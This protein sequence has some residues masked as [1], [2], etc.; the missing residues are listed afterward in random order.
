MQLCWDSRRTARGPALSTPAHQSVETRDFHD[1]MAMLYFQE[2]VD[3]VQGPW[4]SAA[5][6]TELWEVTLPQLARTN[7]TL[8]C[9]AIGIGALSTCHHQSTSRPPHSIREEDTHYLTAVKYYCQSLKLLGQRTS[10]QEAV[11]ISVL[12][13]F[14][15]L[16]RGNRKAA[17][18][19][20]NHG[21][22]L[23]LTL[24]TDENAP[25]LLHAL[26]PDP[27]PLLLSVVGI[28]ICLAPQARFLLHGTAGQDRP[29]PHFTRG[30]KNNDLSMESFMILLGQL[31]RRSATSDE[32]PSTFRN[33]EEFEEHWTSLRRRNLAVGSMGTKIVQSSG[34]LGSKEEDVID[35]FYHHLLEDPEINRFC[36]TSRQAMQAVDAAFLPLFNRI[37]MSGSDSPTFLKAVHLRLQFLQVY[38]FENPPQYLS[39]ETLHAQTPLF[40]EY[41]SLARVALR[42]AQQRG[43]NPA[44]QISLECGI[45]WHLLLVAFFCRDPLTRDEAVQMLREYPCQDGL[46][47]VQ[48]LYTLALKSQAVERTNAVEGTS[49]EQWRRLWR[50]EYVF[51]DG[52]NRIV[53][54]YQDKDETGAWQ[55]VEEVAEVGE[56]F[57][58][59]LWTRRAVTGFGALMMGDLVPT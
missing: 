39:A 40:R 21:L 4:I 26:A 25:Q 33:L 27:N 22:A 9:I 18:N 44:C 12:L 11:F 2:F 28:L 13:L 59:V 19:H 5:S 30:L 37:V 41:L 54:R 46:W 15:E 51:E 10:V 32:I 45:S 58:V 17:L 31:P 6:S 34:V 24:V 36:E 52:G 42:I 38:A 8:R 23:M 56:D 55:M 1:T 16:L 20:L 57:H 29:L 35:N 3:L 50:R 48:S 14:F 7:G 47:N 43:S 49:T 53:F